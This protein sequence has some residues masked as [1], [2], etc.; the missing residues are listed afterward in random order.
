MFFLEATY[1][2]KYLWRDDMVAAKFIEDTYTGTG[3]EENWEA[4]YKTIALMRKTATEVGSRL[5]FPYPQDMDRRTVA[6]LQKVKN[7]SY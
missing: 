3:P 6:Y 2:A 7:Q 4:L 5:G 1:V